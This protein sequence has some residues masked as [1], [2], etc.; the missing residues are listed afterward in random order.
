[1][2]LEKFL[3]GIML[4]TSAL[5]PRQ[6][7]LHPRSARGLEGRLSLMKA[8]GLMS[9]TSLDGIDAAAV[10][11]E[12]EN[13]RFSAQLSAFACVPWDE[14]LRERLLAAC[15]DRAST[16]EVARL[17]AE[18]GRAFG[19]AAL[20]VLEVAR[21]QAPEVAVI[22]SHGQTI[23]H[24]GDDGFTL[25]IG[26]LASIAV[27]TGVAVAGN[28]RRHDVA[29]GG[30]GAPLSPWA[31]WHLLSSPT[32]HRIVHNI[33]GMANLTWLPRGARAQDVRAW[34]SGPGNALL[35]ECAR[36]A[37]GGEHRC[38]WNGARAQRGHLD[39]AWLRTW[40][41]HPFFERKPPKSCGRE[42]FGRAFASQFY[43]AGL[44]R[45]LS[46]DDILANA[47]RLVAWSM[48]RAYAQLRSQVLV[49]QAE[50]T[51]VILCGGGAFNPALRAALEAEAHEQVGLGWPVR[52]LEEVGGSSE[53]R[54]A[55]AFALMACAALAGEP[56]TLPQVTGASRA[57]VSGQIARP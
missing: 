53:A 24:A 15:E 26:D 8:I 13:G 35:D 43:D 33:G 50:P 29:L 40:Q 36:L 14:G 48:A 27:R 49:A 4:L 1:V 12:H 17:D 51:E 18:C 22:G 38:D 54:E 32:M 28:F 21:W 23:F 37:S 10:E 20:Q 25:Q 6:A 5:C 44:Q 11:V 55:V 7:P 39:P 16:G 41:A 46:S 56:N 42:E 19:Q 52:S 30:Q 3:F 9:G 34:D 57:C 2:R 31:D 45:G 47:T